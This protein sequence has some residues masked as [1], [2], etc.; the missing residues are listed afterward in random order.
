MFYITKVVSLIRKDEYG[1]E[2]SS[3]RPSAR[4]RT[5]SRRS[6][7]TTAFAWNPTP[8]ICTP[9]THR[10]RP[11]ARSGNKEAPMDLYDILAAKALNGGGGG[12]EV[13]P[14]SVTENGEYTAPEGTAY[15]PVTVNVPAGGGEVESGVIFIDYDGTIIESW[16]SSAVAGKTALPDN[17]SHSRLVA[18]GWNWDLQHI[19]DYIEDYPEA[20]VV[21]GQYYDTKSG[22]T[23]FNIMLTKAT[24][25]TVTCDMVGNKDW[26]D[27]TTDALTSHTYTDYGDYIVT[28][29]G[30]S[31]PN[32]VFGQTSSAR[33]KYCVSAFMPAGLLSVES[34]AFRWC[35][36]L[37]SVTISPVGGA[38]AQ[39]FSFCTYLKAVVIPKTTTY[40]S[41]NTC[42]NCQMLEFFSFSQDCDSGSDQA[43]MFYYC[44]SLRA[45]TIPTKFTTVSQGMFNDARA[46]KHII[47]PEGIT[48][49][50]SNAFRYCA[51]T[52]LVLPT[53][54]KSVPD[55]VFEYMPY[56]KTLK[57]L[58]NV[59]SV[60]RV[61]CS[62]LSL[63]DLTACTSVPT[64]Q[65]SG[66]FQS[67]NPEFRILVPDALYDDWIVAT[68]WST[69]A[70]YIYKASEVTD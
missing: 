8:A 28:C 3:S 17:P 27:G 37:K 64:L 42:E 21:V 50:R 57:F 34:A 47:I 60:G 22:L 70:D 20:V 41:Y 16:E 9:T 59:T 4:A 66:S 43:S 44:E 12:A 38:S 13:V 30:T 10:P 32:S 69:Y 46:L 29:D 5:K 23:E 33:N 48:I 11:G 35:D 14:L 6:T 52:D 7:R 40:T 65:Y 1:R 24:G 26:G 68:N 39:M 51:F 63:I 56:L 67:S 18:Q 58:G 25:L 15:N 61:P 53:S 45:I 49:I 19:Q 2:R 62:Y 55:S 31:M 54:L 36:G